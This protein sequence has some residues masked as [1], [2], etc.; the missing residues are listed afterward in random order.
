MKTIITFIFVACLFTA[1]FA[2]TQITQEQVL[3]LESNIRFQSV[4]KQFVRDR[5]SYVSG[6]D[7]TSGSTAGLTPINWAKQRTIS[8]SI[9]LHPNSQNYQEWVSQFTMFLKGQNV[10]VTDVDGTITAM[11]ASGKFDE[12]AGL[13]FALRT[14]QIEF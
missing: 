2:Q 4:T 14:Q 5:A 6:Q 3:L 12:L 9:V 10:W 13:V 8:A 1:S 7:G 11:I